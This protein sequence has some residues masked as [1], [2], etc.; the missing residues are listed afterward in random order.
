MSARNGSGSA[1][2]L[3]SSRGNRMA[4]PPACALRELRRLFARAGDGDVQSGEREMHFRN[5][6]KM[7]F[8]RAILRQCSTHYS[9]SKSDDLRGMIKHQLRHD[10]FPLLALVFAIFRVGI[11]FVPDEYLA[12]PRR[13][14][15][16]TVSYRECV[17]HFADG[18]SLRVK[19][20]P[21]IVFGLQAQRRSRRETGNPAVDGVR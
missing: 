12:H 18:L 20:T 4:L 16:H 6:R 1:V 9:A 10:Y 19:Q 2:G 13:Y 8:V 15:L 5:D 3:I 14:A 7:E 17:R 21:S 11:V